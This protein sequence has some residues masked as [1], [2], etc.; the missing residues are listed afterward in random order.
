MAYSWIHTDTTGQA[1]ARARARAESQAWDTS[2]AS[3]AELRALAAHDGTIQAR[4]VGSLSK[5]E[6]EGATWYGAAVPDLYDPAALA[7]IPPER[8]E[9]ART[10]E[11]TWRLLSAETRELSPLPPLFR[12]TDA[13]PPV[14]A[15]AETGNVVVVVTGIVVGG[16]AVCYLGYQTAQVIDRELTRR[17][18][19]RALVQ[20]HAA[21]Q[22]L[23]ET[24]VEREEREGR[25]LPLD[26][27]TKAL[28]AQLGELQRQTTPTPP[29]TEREPGSE[30][31]KAI[32]AAA[33]I[34]ALALL[35][36]PLIQAMKG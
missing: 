10:L 27:A 5:T 8:L 4:L 19:S 35:G 26:A 1:L 14:A 17:A 13:G 9:T 23:V 6:Q 16:G 31:D 24:H 28:L 15:A 18:S 32:T 22:R 29:P 25:Q 11:L 3:V 7:E 20:K 21:A 30:W 12:T 34:A 33:V 2:P 36:P